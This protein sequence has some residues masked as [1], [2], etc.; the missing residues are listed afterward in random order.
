MGCVCR[1]VDLILADFEKT[2]C[3]MG[4]FKNTFCPLIQHLDC[5]CLLD[6]HGLVVGK[7][8][9]SAPPRHNTAHGK[10]GVCSCY[11]IFSLQPVPCLFSACDNDLSRWTAKCMESRHYPRSRESPKVTHA[12][13][14]QTRAANCESQATRLWFQV[15]W[16]VC[17][18]GD[19]WH[20]KRHDSILLFLPKCS[21]VVL[22]V[23]NLWRSVWN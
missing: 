12:A 9:P 18:A 20:I 19:E 7:R 13:H 3:F 5:L 8:L 1:R 16:D 10:T 15:T 23:S 22:C 11:F 4:R 6:S 21:Y 2:F 17:Q 14:L